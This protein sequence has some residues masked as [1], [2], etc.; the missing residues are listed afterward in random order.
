MPRLVVAHELVDGSAVFLRGSACATVT[1]RHRD[2]EECRALGRM[3]DIGFLR[4][5]RTGALVQQLDHLEFSGPSG[6]PD[7]DAVPGFHDV[8]GFHGVA[9]EADVP[10]GDSFRCQ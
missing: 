5:G 9:V 1:S 2:V 10:A 8:G 4:D 6:F 7:G 3:I